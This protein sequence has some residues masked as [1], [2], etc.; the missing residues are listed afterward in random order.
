MSAE[1]K[2]ENKKGKKKRVGIGTILCPIR[3][4]QFLVAVIYINLI[5]AVFFHIL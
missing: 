2:R 4:R 1:L 5:F 3:T